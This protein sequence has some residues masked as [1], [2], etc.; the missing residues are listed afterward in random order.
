MPMPHLFASRLCSTA[1][2]D[3]RRSTKPTIYCRLV[4]GVLVSLGPIPLARQLRS[5]YLPKCLGLADLLRQALHPRAPA[6]HLPSHRPLVPGLHAH[7]TLPPQE[8]CL[9]LRR[10]CSLRALL[11][12][13]LLLGARHLPQLETTRHRRTLPALVLAAALENA[14]QRRGALLE[15]RRASGC[16]R[17]RHTGLGR[18]PGWRWRGWLWL[19]RHLTLRLPLRHLLLTL[20]SRL[21]LEV[22]LMCCLQ[23][24]DETIELLEQSE[25]R[26]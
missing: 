11:G 17:A 20:G 24:S 25:G 22:G 15:L 4:R 8:E 7:P 6:W 5:R 19:E 23:L 3:A 9:Q 12:A 18:A 16:H 14:S 1:G 21:G 10:L 2:R 13:A 26:A